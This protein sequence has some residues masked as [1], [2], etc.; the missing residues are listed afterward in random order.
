MTRCPRWMIALGCAALLGCT[1]DAEALGV[2]LDALAGEFTPIDD[3]RASASYR[4]A[5][6]SSLMEKFWEEAFA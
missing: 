1:P 2:V 5:M 6:V 3:V 4:A